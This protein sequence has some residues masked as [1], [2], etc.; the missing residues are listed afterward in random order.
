M[1]TA[2]YITVE[3]AERLDEGDQPLR[4][5]LRVMRERLRPIYGDPML[6]TKDEDGVLT[7]YEPQDD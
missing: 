7:D 4:E 1:F 2:I 3:E 5:E 6:I